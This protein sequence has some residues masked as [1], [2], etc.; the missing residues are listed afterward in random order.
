[1]QIFSPDFLRGE[2]ETQGT[3]PGQ[4]DKDLSKNKTKEKHKTR[5]QDKTKTVLLQH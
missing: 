2:K 1:M 5:K 4:K 3:V